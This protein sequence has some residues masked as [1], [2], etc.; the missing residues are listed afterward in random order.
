MNPLYKEAILKASQ[1]RKKLGIRMF[2]PI[3]VYDACIEMG[4][5]VRFVDISMEGFYI[6]N[7]VRPSILISN[8]RPFP[9]RIFTCA[10]ELGHHVF[11]HGLKLD[12]L[13]EE[14]EEGARKDSDEILVDAFASA[15]LM[16]IGGIQAEFIKRNLSFE[17]ATPTDFY[18]ICSVFGVGYQTLILNCR[19]N[20]LINEWKF[21]SLLKSSPSKI[22]KSK[23][24]EIEAKSYFRIIDKYFSFTVVDLEVKNYLIVPRSV[25]IEGSTL[26]KVL[27]TEFETIYSANKAGIASA[28]CD[29]TKN[30]YFVRVQKSNYVGLANY[31]H[32]EN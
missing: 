17:T 13:S 21:S 4:I 3:N 25:T 2:Q 20:G 12:V 7:D 22:F 27:E 15:L 9:R 26:E 23:F 28:Y 29:E 10:H 24:H 30:G 14:N 5:D 16:P 31:R 18:T 1:V 19:A 8:Q 32:L 11:G 6:Q